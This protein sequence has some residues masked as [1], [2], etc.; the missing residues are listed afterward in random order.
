MSTL[1]RELFPSAP[2]QASATA[3][4]WS[5]AGARLGS[6]DNSVG[7]LGAGEWEVGRRELTSIVFSV[8]DSQRSAALSCPFFK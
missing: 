4:P 6:R 2:G 3:G 5:G 1:R 7:G 8:P